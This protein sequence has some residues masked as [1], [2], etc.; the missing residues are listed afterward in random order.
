MN[1]T[2]AILALALAATSAH[3]DPMDELI[4]ATG[5]QFAKYVA[6]ERYVANKSKEE[7]AQ[8]AETAEHA[9][10]MQRDL[11]RLAVMFVYEQPRNADPASMDMAY[12]NA[13][14]AYMQRQK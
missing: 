12:F 2:L 7:S 3:A 8:F 13:C 11:H 4:C 9:N 10:E 1:K 14:V 6:Y 5:A